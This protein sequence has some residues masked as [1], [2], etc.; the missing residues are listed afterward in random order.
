MKLGEWIALL[1]LVASIYILWQIKDVLML[2]FAA[3][4]LANSLNLLARWLQKKLGIKRAIAVLIAIGTL[5]AALVL[6]FQIIVPSFSKQIQE[7][8]VLVPQGIRQLNVWLNSIND[9]VPDNL[10]RYI[11]DL[12]SLMQQAMPFGNRLLGG[13]FA[14]F[15]SSLGA[16]INVLLIV[17]LGLMML[18]NPSAYRGGFIR[19]FP[20]FYR[21]RV[22][23]ILKECETSLG[24]WIVGALISMSVIAVLSTL[25]LSIIGVKAAL[26]N[27]VLAGLLNF[28]PNLGPAFSVV[29]PMAIALIDSPV[30]ALLV[31]GLY[32]AIQQFE[33]NFLTPYV[34][35][36][37]VNLLPAVTLLAQVFFATIFGFWGLLL[38][39]P[40]V[41][42]CQ[43]WIRRVLIEDI[44]DPWNAPPHTK[45]RPF[46]SPNPDAP[47]AVLTETVL[48]PSSNPL[49]PDDL[50]ADVTDKTKEK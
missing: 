45:D 25:G 28:I 32:I 24:S 43:I 8:Y 2:L 5:V 20:S 14:F 37:Q 13:S 30:K 41:V 26:A 1:A 40:L 49:E 22:D 7:I 35:S 19:F 9:V 23:D 12:D 27:G 31:L 21:R 34:M 47:P 3:V 17:V 10:E 6:F 42:V 11:P 15:S 48:Q 16:V 29:P 39:L 4:V 33:S 44:M 36:Q 46:Q 38:A 50:W 18:V